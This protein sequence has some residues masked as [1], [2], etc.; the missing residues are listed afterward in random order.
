MRIALENLETLL[1]EE[2]ERIDELRRFGSV[3]PAVYEMLYV[4]AREG[5]IDV[6]GVIF[7]ARNCG[8]LMA[9]L[10]D[11]VLTHENVASAKLAAEQIL[12]QPYP[13]SSEHESRFLLHA[14]LARQ[15]IGSL[16]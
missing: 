11:K 3:S 1:A 10:I 7:I 13:T 6:S 5:S 9:F 8:R 2:C 12:L 4:A 16:K 15:S 14:W